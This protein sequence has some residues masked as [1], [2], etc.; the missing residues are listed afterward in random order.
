MQPS[1][2]LSRTSAL[3]H[4]LKQ[5]PEPVIFWT[6][7]AGY[8]VPVWSFR[9]L[10]TQDGPAHVFNAQIV[11]DYLVSSS[12]PYARYYEVRP[13]PLPNWTC[14]A[15]LATLLF[16]FPPL[17]A[18]KVL[19]SLYI[20]GFAAA[21]RYFLGAFGDR[22]RPISWAGLLFVYNHCFWMGF[23]SYCLSLVLLWT[24]L[25]FWLRRRVALELPQAA[26]LMLLLTAQF[27]TH[28]VG[29]VLAFTGVLA[30]TVLTPPRRLLGPV[31]VC[32]AALP[33]SCL[34]MDYFERT[35]FFQARASHRLVDHPLAMLKGK[36]PDTDLVDNLEKIDKEVF[37]HHAGAS[38]PFS[39]YLV[40]Y[41]T[42]L[43]IFSLAEYRRRAEEE[44]GGPGWLFPLLLSILCLGIFLL[45]PDNL[46]LEHGGYLKARFAMLPPMVWLACLRESSRPGFC[47]LVRSMLLFLLGANLVL[48]TEAFESGNR[49]VAQ[50]TAGIEAVGR[51]H[52]IYVNHHDEPPSQ[53][54]KPLA[55]AAYHYCLGTNNITLDNYEANLPHFPI[56]YRSG[57]SRG[58]GGWAGYP[59]QALV[60]TI[61]SWQPTGWRV[62][63]P[64]WEEIFSQGPLRIYRR[65]TW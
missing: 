35:G 65:P 14:H 2:P 53:L 16:L 27:F 42:L 28:L 57:I 51:G 13:D 4:W 63:P 32:L 10:P 15:V 29:F 34:V 43:G 23:Y 33:A 56:K 61:V 20:V 39:I 48:V 12:S 45:V 6:L 3:L 7:V 58:R 19:A 9:Y 36:G 18:E 52:R 1:I 25:G 5:H 50:Y 47:W 37:E 38:I 24:I 11:K 8:L 46:S 22:C 26:V 54:V 40:P 55:H 49:V 17:I 30:M 62:A 31:L 64:D 21:F 44:G 60:D 41:Y 59:N